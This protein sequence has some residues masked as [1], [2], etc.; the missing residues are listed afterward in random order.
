VSWQPA[1][2]PSSVPIEERRAAVEAGFVYDVDAAH[3]HVR[4]MLERLAARRSRRVTPSD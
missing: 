3:P 2:N 1:P 4:V